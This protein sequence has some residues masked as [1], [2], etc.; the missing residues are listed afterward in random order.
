MRLLLDQGL[1]RTAAALLR[2]TGRDAVHTGEC[3][4]ATASDSAILDHARAEVQVVVTLDADFHALMALSGATNPSV[5]RIRVEGLRADAL[6]DILQNVLVQ[7][8]ED[9]TAGALV[10]VEQDR[11]RVRRLPIQR[12]G[13]GS[14][15]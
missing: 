9:L 8:G 5:I 6:A 7:C 13:H 11:V 3:G 14:H 15:R 12:G 4:L 2:D 1:P 10:S